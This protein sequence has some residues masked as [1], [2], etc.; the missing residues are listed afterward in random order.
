[1]HTPYIELLSKDENDDKQKITTTHMT[2]LFKLTTTLIDLIAKAEKVPA[3]LSYT[4]VASILMSRHLPDL[5]A[6]LLE[7]A[8]APASA[9]Q[10]TTLITE[11]VH[12]MPLTPGN[13]A[14][15]INRTGLS[16]EERDKCARMFMWLFDRS[17]LSRAMESLMSLLSTSSPSHPIPNWLRTICGRFLSRIL[18]KPNGVSIVL[19]FTI[20]HVDQCEL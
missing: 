2:F 5:Y 10:P 7:L 19:E 9:F 16:R 11:G 1:M 3:S 15:P 8:Y 13:I 4:T 18:L 12:H 6:A 20:G 17:D 14:R